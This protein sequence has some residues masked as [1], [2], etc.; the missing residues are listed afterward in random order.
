MFTSKGNF[1]KALEMHEQALKLRLSVL[2]TD[3][4]SFAASLNS[5]GAVHAYMNKFDFAVDYYSKALE[6]RVK[7]FGEKH[8]AVAATCF[9]LG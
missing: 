2:G 3:H 9:N 6:L 4:P 5:I 1:K 8:L 7:I